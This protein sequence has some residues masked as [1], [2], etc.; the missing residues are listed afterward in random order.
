M[1][2]FVAMVSLVVLAFVLAAVALIVWLGRLFGSIVL[3]CVVL[4]L[5]SIFI[6]YVIYRLNLKERLASILNDL[7]TFAESVTALRRG[8]GWMLS[9]VEH[10]AKCREESPH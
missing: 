4:S 1:V 10:F 7:H 3:P 2:A 6:A 5:L 8:Y 9:I